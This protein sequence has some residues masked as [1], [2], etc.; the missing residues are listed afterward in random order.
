MDPRITIAEEIRAARA[1]DAR[2][3]ALGL[4]ALSARYDR[5]A[6]RVLVEISNG[7]LFG[8]PVSRVAALAD[9]TPSQLADVEVSPGGTALRWDAL[10]VDLS[11]SGLLL[12]SVGRRQRLQELARLAG[13]VTS[14]AK[15]RAA[16]ANG[17]KGGRP[18][19][20]KA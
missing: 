17:A 18:R 14:K 4:R 11:V 10:D 15:A 2:E 3:R 19:K 5:R 20:S 16:R 1:R 6:T 7:C 9:A 8:F 13:Q 12:D